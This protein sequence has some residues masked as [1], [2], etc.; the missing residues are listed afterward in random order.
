MTTEDII[1]LTEVDARSKSNTKRIDSLEKTLEE[2]HRLATSVEIIARELG[3][4]TEAVGE[5]KEKVSKL[6]AKVETIEKKPGKRWEAVAEKIL[7]VVVGAI[8]AIVLKQIGL[9]A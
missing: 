1:H 6:D 8:A 7:L 4:Q 2:F 5:I 9:S 3:H